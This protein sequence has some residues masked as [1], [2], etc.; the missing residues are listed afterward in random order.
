MRKI[1]LLIVLLISGY[2]YAKDITHQVK[3]NTDFDEKIAQGCSGKCGNRGYSR[4]DSININ[5]GATGF[6]KVILK[7]TARYLDHKDPPKVMGVKIGGG[8]G[9]KYTVKVTAY[10]T[11]SM[12]NCVMTVD[13]IDIAGDDLGI[14][15]GV[16]K[17][18]G[19][20]YHLKNCQQYT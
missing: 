4:L 18:Q 14:A 12:S 13:R 16:K 20:H 1:T 7:A 15:N 8:V 19:K 3:V 10:G 11:L 6:Y 5:S 17:E 2:A 9:V